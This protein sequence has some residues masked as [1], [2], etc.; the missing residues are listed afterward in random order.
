M[1]REQV[2]PRCI[3]NSNSQVARLLLTSN[4]SRT[5]KSRSFPP[6]AR[7]VTS[8]RIVP[9]PLVTETIWSV[10]CRVFLPIKLSLSQIYQASVHLLMNS[11]SSTLHLKVPVTLIF[12]YFRRKVEAF[13]NHNILKWLNFLQ[14]FMFFWDVKCTIYALL[15]CLCVFDRA[16]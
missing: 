3:S 6:V 2:F 7:S 12:F 8:T 13:T 5:R 16:N 1:L 11:S 4:T 15:R 10:V 14:S 9:W